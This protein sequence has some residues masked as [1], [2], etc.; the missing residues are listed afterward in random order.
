MIAYSSAIDVPESDI[1]E[2]R[3]Y[4]VRQERA[5]DGQIFPP[6][7]KVSNGK[8]EPDDVY[9]AV[10]YRDSWFWID[11]RDLHSKAMFSFLVILKSFTERENGQFAA[12]VI[13]VPTN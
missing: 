7:I 5:A 10:P 12:P 2:G 8:I 1:A 9:V 3:V 13:S 6:F 11:D 4:A